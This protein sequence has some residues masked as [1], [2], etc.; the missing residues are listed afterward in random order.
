VVVKILQSNVC[1]VQLIRSIFE[2]VKATKLPCSRHLCRIIPLSKVFFAN[3]TEFETNIKLL[4][5]EAFDLPEAMTTAP[6]VGLKEGAVPSETLSSD[7]LEEQPNKKQKQD[8]EATPT[9]PIVTPIDDITSDTTP[10]STM[11]GGCKRS[12]EQLQ[13]PNLL[14]SPAPSRLLPVTMLFKKRNHNTLNRIWVQQQIFSN[15]PRSQCSVDF[16]HPKVPVLPRPSCWHGVVTRLALLAVSQHEQLVAR[17]IRVA[18]MIE[19]VKHP[20]DLTLSR[21]PHRL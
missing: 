1:P 11:E 17:Q 8:N 16:K 14:P 13:A 9:V 18:T 15:I 2:K 3:E 4:I 5:A 19:G 6:I 12:L 20:I 21:P 10:P 7:E